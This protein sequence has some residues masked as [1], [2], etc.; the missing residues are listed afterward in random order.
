MVIKRI[1]IQYQDTQTTKT[2]KTAAFTKTKGPEQKKKKKPSQTVKPPET[3]LPRTHNPH[4]THCK[5]PHH[6]PSVVLSH[7]MTVPPPNPNKKKGL[8]KL[9]CNSLHPLEEPHPEPLYIN[10][11][12]Q[13]ATSPNR[14]CPSQPPS[15]FPTYPLV[16][17]ACT[18]LRQTSRPIALCNV[19]DLDRRNSQRCPIQFPPSG[20]AA[21]A[22]SDFPVA[23]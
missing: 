21:A 16:T 8:S 7:C 11:T 23:A 18:K 17:A 6:Q 19:V 13:S 10:N 20:H 1:N 22:L 5:P 14:C 15:I 9:H 4:S 3:I 2:P 12:L